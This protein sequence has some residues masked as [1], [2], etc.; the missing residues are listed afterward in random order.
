MMDDENVIK[1]YDAGIVFKVCE[2]F[3]ETEIQTLIKRLLKFILF[4]HQEKD[5]SYYY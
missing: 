2:S 1:C 5:I 4:S 3:M